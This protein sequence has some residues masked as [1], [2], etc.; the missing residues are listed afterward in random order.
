M[1][2]VT[3]EGVV[4]NVNKMDD[5]HLLNTIRLFVTR[6]ELAKKIIDGSSKKFCSR[7]NKTGF[8]KKQAYDFVDAFEENFPNYLY[9]AVIRGLDIESSVSSLR[10]IIEREQAV[11]DE[12]LL[13][14]KSKVVEQFPF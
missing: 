7:I 10:T 8:S 11:K 14:I 5:S 9:E 6:L 2:H 4:M 13:L 12:P 3:A 1:N